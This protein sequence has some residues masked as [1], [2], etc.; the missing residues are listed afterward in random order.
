M[1]TKLMSRALVACLAA[2][3]GCGSPSTSS[4][5][6]YI[7]AIAAAQCAWEF[8]CCTDAEIMQREMSKFKDQT[9]CQQFKELS[10]ENVLYLESLAVR[11]GR[12]TVDQTN[13]DACV[14]SI[15]NDPCNP[16]PGTPPPPPPT[17]GMVDPCTVVFKG[18]TP[19]GDECDFA[20]ECVKGAHCVFTGA[21]G[22]GVCVPYQEEKEICNSSN[23]CDPT[24]FNLYCA[25]LDYT[26]HLRSQAGGPCAYTIEPVSGMPTTPLLLECDD[27]QGLLY[28]DPST[29]LC[30]AMPGDGQPCLAT[31]LPPGVF[32]QCA[33]GLVCDSATAGG[34]CRGPGDVG[35]D[36]TRVPCKTTLYCDR[37]MVPNTCK[38]LPTLNEPCQQSNYQC[39]KPYYCNTSVVPYVCAQPAPLGA[40]CSN[41]VLCDTGLYCD[42]TALPTTCKEKLPDGS[43]CTSSPMCLSNLCVFTT[44]GGTCAP[45]TV[46]VQCIGR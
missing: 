9:A 10:L 2:L 14:S 23:D 31:P 4:V 24:V 12:V 38:T 39:Q 40:P 18:A 19:I 26:C 1:K 33:P 13:A 29:M 21:G 16:A 27:S 3:G 17:P 34:I 11:E 7:K 15:Q 41:T 35:A 6:N 46:T 43:P 30:A 22:R 37:S 20:N 28:C 42:M 45:S 36:C 8:R 5:D 25:R 44:N 32:R